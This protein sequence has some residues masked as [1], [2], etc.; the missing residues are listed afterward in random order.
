MQTDNRFSP[1]V[2]ALLD[3]T[4]EVRIE[5]PSADGQPMQPVIIW[6]VVLDGRDV[7]VRS[8]RGVKGRWYQQ[9]LKQPQ[10]RGRLHVDQ[11]AIPVRAVHIDDPEII[12]RVSDAFRK[13]YESKWPQETAEMVRDDVL[14]TTLRLDPDTP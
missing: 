9:L 5:P 1:D 8:Y 4:D 6:V 3:Q 7:Y 12:A 2:V 11:R 10:H 13:K 14:P